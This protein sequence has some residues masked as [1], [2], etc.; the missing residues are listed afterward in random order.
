M[1]PTA[2][3]GLTLR[4]L[5]HRDAP[6]LLAAIA[7][8]RAHLTAFGDYA[9]LSAMTLAQLEAE[10]AAADDKTRFGI[11]HDGQLVGRAD[12]IA[13]DPPNYGIGYWLAAHATG[14]GYATAAVAAL[15]D[16]ARRLPGAAALYAGV[17]HGNQR[18][19]AVLERV[20]FRQVAR[21]ERH[22]RFHLAL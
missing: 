19:I 5:V 14:K 17:T 8:N 18:S 7:D 21:F 15:V 11:F 3:P 20:G 4:E 16:Q 13:V 6:D 2:I 1:I 12:L 10:L 9:E 22:A